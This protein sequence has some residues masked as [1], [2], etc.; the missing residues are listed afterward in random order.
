MRIRF[1][2]RQVVLKETDQKCVNSPYQRTLCSIHETTL[3]SLQS[4]LH[5]AATRRGVFDRL[6]NIVSNIRQRSGRCYQN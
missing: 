6:F 1:Q 5:F 3:E 2:S 4:Q